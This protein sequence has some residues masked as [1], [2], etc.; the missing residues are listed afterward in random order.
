MKTKIGTAITM[1]AMATSLF[2]ASCSNSSNK[3][4]STSETHEHQHGE[5]DHHEHIFACPMHPEVTGKE[6]DKCPKCGMALEHIDEVPATG[7]FQM[8]FTSSPQI[9]EADN[10]VTLA[11]TP[12]NKDNPNA[13]VP[14]DM[15]HEKKLHLILV[16]EDLSWFNHIHPDYQTDGTYSVAETFPNGGNY[17]LYADYK[18]SGS[19]HQL[20][21]INVEVKGKTIPAKTFTKTINTAVSDAYSITL[22]PDDGIFIA[23]KA[24]HFDGVFTNEGKPFDVNQLQNHLGAKGHMVA[25]NIET[26]EYVHLHPEV[27]GTVLHFHTTFENAGIYRA[28][29]QFMADGKL[30]TVDFV[31]NVEKGQVKTTETQHDH[32]NHSD[33]KH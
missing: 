12:K 11:F 26:K 10:P 19:T 31:I 23:N 24:I 4:E 9:I 28:W 16:S 20:E 7:N 32:N 18:P 25:I 2:I 33:H 13:V 21:K 8:Q 1:C 22:K 27:E 15:E 14:L 3:T 30:H 29:L 17:I 6:G 5:G